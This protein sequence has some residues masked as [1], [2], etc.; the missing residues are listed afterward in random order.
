MI[1]GRKRDYITSPFVKQGQIVVLKGHNLTHR[2][3]IPTELPY[4]IKI[5]QL[6]SGLGCGNAN[7]FF[8]VP[9]SE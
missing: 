6:V 5:L 8:K 2:L 1:I 4:E 7:K 9:G 3:Q